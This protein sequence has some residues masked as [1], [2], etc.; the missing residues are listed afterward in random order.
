MRA[1]RQWPW[2]YQLLSMT[3]LRLGFPSCKVRTIPTSQPHQGSCPAAALAGLCLQWVTDLPGDVPQ[4]SCCSA[5]SAACCCRIGA[6]GLTG[7]GAEKRNT[8]GSRSTYPPTLALLWAP[9]ERVGNESSSS[10]NSSLT[11]TVRGFIREMKEKNT[12]FVM[13]K[14]MAP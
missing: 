13:E 10:Q 8:R 1:G 5:L 4:D 3:S 14:A 6:A 9:R 2:F 12:V 7:V 11:N